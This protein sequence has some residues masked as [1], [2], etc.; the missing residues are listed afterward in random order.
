M[1]LI[2]PLRSNARSKLFTGTTFPVA[3]TSRTMSPRFASDVR[4]TGGFFKANAAMPPPARSAAM[5]MSKPNANP[6]SAMSTTT[7]IA[8]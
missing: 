6:M 1:W 2:L 8:R 5:T 7:G 4:S 3:E